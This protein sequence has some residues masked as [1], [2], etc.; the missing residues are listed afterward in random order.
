MGLFLLWIH[1]LTSPRYSI[2]SG[3]SSNGSSRQVSCV[4]GYDGLP[5]AIYCHL[6]NWTDLSGC[7]IVTCASNP[8]QL[9]YVIRFGPVYLRLNSERDLCSWIHWISVIHCLSFRFF[10]D[11]F[12]WVYTSC[13]WYSSRFSRLCAWIWLFILWMHTLLDLLHWLWRR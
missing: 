13:L 1:F 6:G 12:L 2:A 10:V 11:P 4:V 5:S 8:T 3:S 9:H 7:D